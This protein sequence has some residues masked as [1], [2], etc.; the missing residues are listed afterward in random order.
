[1]MTSNDGDHSTFYKSPVTTIYDT[2]GMLLGQTVT[3]PTIWI[4]GPSDLWIEIFIA[5]TFNAIDAIKCAENVV[6]NGVHECIG[7][8][9][10]INIFTVSS[11]KYL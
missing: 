11:G 3:S 5:P 8:G 6:L 9:H 7:T 1:M 10:F 2:F 4:D